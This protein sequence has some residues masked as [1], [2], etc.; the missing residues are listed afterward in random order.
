MNGAEVANEAEPPTGDANSSVGASLLVRLRAGQ[1]GAW[2][3]LVRLYGPTVYL[4]CRG[5]GVSE[6]DAADVRCSALVRHR[7]GR[8]G[9][10]TSG[11][12]P[13]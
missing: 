7:A 4:W 13:E 5:D 9:H 8:N 3:R 11:C 1:A 12:A 2:E 10:R 6:A